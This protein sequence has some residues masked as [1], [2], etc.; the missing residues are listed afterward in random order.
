M[1]RPILLVENE[2]LI[3]MPIAAY[4]RDGGYQV[5]EVGNSDEALRV[6]S[7][8]FHIDIIFIAVEIPGSVNVFGL[9]NGLEKTD[10]S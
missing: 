1:N 10:P 5:C 4:L 8:G 6:L 7:S 3:R 9:R 2:V